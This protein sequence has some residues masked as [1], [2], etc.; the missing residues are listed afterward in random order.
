MK[1]PCVFLKP[2]EIGAWIWKMIHLSKKIVCMMMTAVVVLALFSHLHLAFADTATDVWDG[3]SVAKGFASGSGTAEDPFIIRTAAQLMY[4]RNHVNAT[5]NAYQGKH[6]L[7]DADID[8]NHKTFGDPIGS[9]TRPFYGHFDGNGHRVINMKMES[10]VYF[11][12]LFGYVVEATIENVTIEN[13][14]VKATAANANAG[15]L[16]GQGYGCRISN[17][18]NINTSVTKEDGTT[19][20]NGV[21]GLIGLVGDNGSGSSLKNSII[22]NCTNSGNIR[23]YIR[24]GGIWGCSVGS[25]QTIACT[26]TGNITG[27]DEA[28][29]GIGGYD[30]G[31]GVITKCANKQGNIKAVSTAGGIVGYAQYTQISRCYNTGSVTASGSCAGGICGSANFSKSQ[32]SPSKI[33][34]IPAP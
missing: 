12:G 5:K 19:R 26:N 9:D 34:T 25:T 23:G 6:I 20:Q 30:Y 11:V 13:S 8:L 16:V 2:I 31:T 3:T 24:A 29:G 28:A 10:G 27:V 18:H 15:A 14:L 21:G 17:C 32:Q 22:E 4:F 7:L 33:A 1:V